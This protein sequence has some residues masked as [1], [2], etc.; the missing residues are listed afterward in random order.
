MIRRIPVVSTP[1]TGAKSIIVDGK[2]GLISDGFDEISLSRKITELNDLDL[3]RI[4]NKG[5]NRA[6]SF[7]KA[8]LK[9]KLQTLI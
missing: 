5:Y 9:L 3:K 2:S 4:I 6:M 8:R 1:T 7:S